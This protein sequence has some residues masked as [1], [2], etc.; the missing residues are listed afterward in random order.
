MTG[1]PALVATTAALAFRLALIL[2]WPACYGGDALGRL[3]HLDTPLWSPVQLPL[4][5]V[6]VSAV[7][8]L[9]RLPMTQRL[10]FALVGSLAC[11]AGA[12]LVDRVAGRRAGLLAGLLLAISP[13]L[14][15]WSVVPYGEPLMLALLF[16]G[17]AH[18]YA[19]RHGCERPFALAAL[20]LAT[21]VRYEAWIAALLVALVPPARVRRATRA[22]A[23]VPLLAPLAWIAANRGLSPIGTRSLDLGAGLERLRDAAVTTGGTFLL[24]SPPLFAIALLG[25][26]HVLVRRADLERYQPAE[27]RPLWVLALLAGAFVAMVAGCRPYAPLDNPRQTILPAAVV[28]IFAAIELDLLE[29]ILPRFLYPYPRPR[30]AVIATTLALLLAWP[31]MLG[32]SRVRRDALSA[33][34]RTG[35][36]VGRFLRNHAADVACAVV[37]APARRD[38]PALEPTVARW[39]RVQSPGVE[40]R[41]ADARDP[42]L[43][44][45]CWLVMVG[46]SR[47]RCQGASVEPTPA[48][49][50]SVCLIVARDP[51]TRS[52]RPV[53]PPPGH[54]RA[55]TDGTR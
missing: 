4:T 36:A 48:A 39:I 29:R 40:V 10:A 23:A 52:P 14:V 41:V 32:V 25:L 53:P 34:A 7:A 11:G 35:H 42:T 18:W 3:E 30:P 27:R 51:G 55:A 28:A 24:S 20:A 44:R 54:G 19:P 12:L 43:D 8:R 21:M 1:R 16:L 47:H 26:R 50:V 33:D 46:P 9:S 6:V 38:F 15:E 17:L 22:A 13:P 49:G 2:A 31:A 45:P 37:D 5:A